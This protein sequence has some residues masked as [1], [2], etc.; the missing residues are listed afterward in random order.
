MQ[1]RHN[2]IG[3]VF[4]EVPI[5]QLFGRGVDE[6]NHAPSLRLVELN[7]TEISLDVPF[8]PIPY[9]VL[10][11]LGEDDRRV[12]TQHIVVLDAIKSPNLPY[13]TEESVPSAD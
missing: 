3:H 2:L 9:R 4:D 11:V 8:P 1:N 7:Q 13:T 5:N 10:F 6:I 12:I